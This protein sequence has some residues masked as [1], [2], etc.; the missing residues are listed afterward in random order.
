MP[1]CLADNGA[2]IVVAEWLQDEYAQPRQQCVVQLEGRILG[3]RA[4]QRDHAFFDG[5]QKGILLG[6]VEAV[7]LIAKE[8]RAA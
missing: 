8:Y 7:D 1:P 4:D 6:L 5:W 2:H 3:G